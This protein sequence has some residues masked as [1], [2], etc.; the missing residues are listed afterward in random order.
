[1]SRRSNDKTPSSYSIQLRV[2]M[3][4]ILPHQGLRLIA[5]DNKERWTPRLLVIAAVL[6][7]WDVS[8]AMID[9]FA[10]A[11]ASLVSMFPT[12]RRPGMCCEGFFRTLARHSQGLL[13]VMVPSLRK[14]VRE[15]AGDRYWRSGQRPA[16]GVD[17]SRSECPMTLSNEKAFG[18]AGKNNTGPQQFITLIFHVGTGMIW[19]YRRGDACASERAHLL[20][21]LATL[22]KDA[23]LLADAGFTGYEFMSSVIA[24][25]RSF[26]I[27]VGANVRL[28]TKLGLAVREHDGIVYLWPQTARSKG[29][30]PL[31]LR[32]ITL[33]DSRNRRIH[34]LSNQLDVAELSDQESVDLY[35]KRWG[36]E[37]IYRSL[38]QT[39][40]KRRMVCDGQTNAQLELD[41]AIIGLW[42]LGMMS[43]EQ[44]TQNGQPPPAWSVAQS[45]RMTRQAARN[46]PPIRCRR[47]TLAAALAQA[48]KDDYERNKSKR[49]RHWPHKKREK[50]PGDPIARIASELEIQLAA[51]FER[52]RGVG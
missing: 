45:L 12:R 8:T 44:I 29:Q 21:M 30:K 40:G 3:S 1:M 39:M 42:L 24:S 16:F 15:L 6:M 52:E 9:R 28:L 38:K 17:G 26:I 20:E 5:K 46:H 4:S 7:A 48:I 10:A 19:D 50:P 37:V 47:Q 13:A 41:W 11:R 31:T 32:L 36:V 35:E 34:L 49:A 2:A 23:M 43:V 25:G 18:T 27:R 33:T 14:R 22:P 51:R